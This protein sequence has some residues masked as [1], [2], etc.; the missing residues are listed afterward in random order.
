MTYTN[1]WEEDWKICDGDYHLSKK[2]LPIFESYL[3]SL[4]EK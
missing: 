1:K 2:M 4:A 3:V